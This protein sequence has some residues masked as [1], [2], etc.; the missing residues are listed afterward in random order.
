LPI[1]RKTSGNTRGT[2][3]KPVPE[4]I[5]KLE[6]VASKDGLKKNKLVVERC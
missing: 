3:T 6:K 5:Y 1:A 2:F 4:S